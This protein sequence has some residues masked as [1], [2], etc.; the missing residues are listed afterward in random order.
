M[1][2]GLKIW[3]EN[4][5]LVFLLYSRMG[6]IGDKKIKSDTKSD[7]HKHNTEARAASEAEKYHVMVNVAGNYSIDRKL[8]L[9]PTLTI[10]QGFVCTQLNQKSFQFKE[11]NDRREACST[12]TSG[13]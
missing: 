5:R 8:L 10:W 13:H 4:L 12:S 9:K 1:N 6:Q 3:P 2:S 7:R 11:P